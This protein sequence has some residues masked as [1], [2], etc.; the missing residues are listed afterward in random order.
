MNMIKVLWWRFQL[1]LGTF[2]IL[3]GE[4]SSQMGLFRHLSD[5][6]LRVRN[7]ENTKSMRVILFP[8]YLKFKLYF[9]NAGN[10]W[11]T[12][13]CFWDNYIWIPMLKSSLFRTGYISSATNSL[14]HLRTGYFWS[15]A[16]VLTRCP[17]IWHVNKRDLLKLNLQ[18]VINKYDKS[19][20][21]LTLT[22]LG[23]V[24]HLAFQGIL[25]NGTF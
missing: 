21:I 16:N 8:N 17:K 23:Q 24:Y 20:K 22:V 6:A 13:F 15:A 10:N 9:K 2:T 25:W 5:Y 18:A 4:A 12:V 11:K 19:A 7:L 3:L 1:C 14:S